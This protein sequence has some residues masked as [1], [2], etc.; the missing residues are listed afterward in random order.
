MSRVW[1]VALVLLGFASEVRGGDIGRDAL[2]FE[3][4][5]RVIANCRITA[6]DLEFGLFDPLGAN[7]L[8]PLDA[9]A[10]VQV[11][12]TRNLIGEFSL[13]QVPAGGL[14]LTDGEYRLDFE[15]FADELRTLDWRG[16]EKPFIGGGASAPSVFTLFGRI[17]AGQ[18]PP[19]GTFVGRLTARVDF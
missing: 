2:A 12:C 5:A 17:P 18:L 9:M 16:A 11:I 1:V 15:L 14:T 8:E 6:T 3:V 10:P 13:G 7:A 19:A 4:E